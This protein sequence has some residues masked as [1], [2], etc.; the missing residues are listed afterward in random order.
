M[1]KA[2]EQELNDEGFEETQSLVSESLSQEASSGNYETDTHDSTRCSPA[3]LTRTSTT[4]ST[5]SVPKI[6]T[7]SIGSGTKSLQRR[8]SPR[9]IQDKSLSRI[10]SFERRDSR[11]SIGGRSS[12]SQEGSS[13]L[14]KRTGSL[15]REPPTR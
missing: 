7:T 12:K 3:E 1:N 9:L 10:K 6:A 11:D 4:T 15:K 8:D 13:Y 14:P 5:A 2:R